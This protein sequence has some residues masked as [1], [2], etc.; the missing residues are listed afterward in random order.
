[1]F[2]K[3]ASSVLG[4]LGFLLIIT[5]VVQRKK[6]L[7]VDG[8]PVVLNTLVKPLIFL[9]MMIVYVA[10]IKHIGFYLSTTVVLGFYMFIMGIRKPSTLTISVVVVMTVLYI[11]FTMMLKIRLPK[12]IWM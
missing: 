9:I 6:N 2:P 12:G 5:T 3:I 11:V 4:I 7:P 1:M 10:A 8:E